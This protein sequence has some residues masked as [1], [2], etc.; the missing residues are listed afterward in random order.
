MLKSSYGYRWLESDEPATDYYGGAL[1]AP[2]QKLV[3]KD[4]CEINWLR[5]TWYS[6][7][8]NLIEKHGSKLSHQFLVDIGCGTGEFLNYIR[9]WFP[10]ATGIDPYGSAASYNTVSSYNSARHGTVHSIVMLNTLEHIPNPERVIQEIK[11]TLMSS[12][13]LLIVRV[14]NDFSILQR[15]CKFV[16]GREPWWI[17]EPDH[18]N[19]FNVK[20]LKRFFKLLDFKIVDII[21]DYPME[22]FLLRRMDYI[23][24]A[25]IGA[26][27]HGRR[28]HFEM[29]IPS[30]VRRALY[31]FLIKFGIGRNV[32]MVVKKNA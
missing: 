14:P 9:N 12:H 3:D 26:E 11:D 30:A 19:Y 23:S 10:S 31:R 8:R 32:M 29:R 22:L 27:C 28:M 7:V 17:I 13:T 16:M 4:P 18:V 1:P 20:S 5:K 15:L 21:G 2:M 24:D 25:G 6:D